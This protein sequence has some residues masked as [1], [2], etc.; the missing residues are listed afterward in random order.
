VKRWERDGIVELEE[1]KLPTE[2]HLCKGVAVIECVQRIPCN[3][4]VD[5]CPVQ[6]ISMDTINDT[7]AIDYER[8]TGCGTCVAVC[9]G[10]AIFL[11]RVRGDRARV[12]IPYEFFPLPEKGQTVAALDREGRAVCKATVIRVLKGATPVVTL[13]VPSEHALVV[14]HF[15]VKP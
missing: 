8:C 10:L 11:V 1:L 15:E 3:P 7:P 9:P 12:S 4:C 6:A 5:A 14:R 13:D 2:E